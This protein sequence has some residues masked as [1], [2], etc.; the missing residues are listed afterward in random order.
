MDTR[1]NIVA[2]EYSK[3]ARRLLV[4][5]TVYRKDLSVGKFLVLYRTMII[6]EDPFLGYR[7]VKATYA[8]L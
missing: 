2:R 8:Q 6:G 5:R 7:W 3:D 1:T 4:V